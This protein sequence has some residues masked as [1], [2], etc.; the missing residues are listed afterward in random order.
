MF[1]LQPPAVRELAL[2]T[3]MPERF[4]RRGVRS[5]WADANRGGRPVDSFL[6][7]PVCDAHGNLYVTDIPFGRIFRIAP[8]LEWELIAEYEGEPNG[9]KLFDDEHS[10]S[11]TVAT[12]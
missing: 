5:V 1:Y 3:A 10:S 8:S 12:G 9:M 4:R 11:P 6:E 2:H 7:G